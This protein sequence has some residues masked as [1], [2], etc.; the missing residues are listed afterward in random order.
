MGNWEEEGKG[1]KIERKPPKE[2]SLEELK[3]KLEF[4]E[5]CSDSYI[6]EGEGSEFNGDPNGELAEYEHEQADLHSDIEM[7]KAMIRQKCW[8]PTV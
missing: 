1:E 7:I 5:W 3:V 2:M 8:A 6:Y 4:L